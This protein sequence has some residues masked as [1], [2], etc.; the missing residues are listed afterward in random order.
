MEFSCD[1]ILSCSFISLVQMDIEQPLE[2]TFRLEEKMNHDMTKQQNECP[3]SE[4]LDQPG[5]PPIL[6]RVFAVRSMGSSGHKLS[7]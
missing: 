4:D 5:H 6:I 2:F 1:L 3:T 7:S